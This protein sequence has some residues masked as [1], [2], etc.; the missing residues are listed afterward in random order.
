MID[1]Y[2][3]EKNMNIRELHTFNNLKIQL[4]L[5]ECENHDEKL[6]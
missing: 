3:F 1:I 2:K 6:E 5:G 4:P